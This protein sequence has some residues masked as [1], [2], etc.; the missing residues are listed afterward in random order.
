LTNSLLCGIEVSPLRGDTLSR[1]YN[2]LEG[3]ACLALNIYHEARDQPIE[4]QV[5]VAQVVMERVKSDKYPNS[6][7]EVVMQGPT[8]SWS[9]NYPIKHRCQF[10]WYCDGLSDRPKDMT[11]YLN[12]VDVAEKT[13]HGLKDVV[14]G[15]MYYHSTKVNPWWAKYKIRVRQIGD[16]IFY[17]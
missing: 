4:G 13:L 3:L 15:S 7:C 12:S 5:A 1:R 10:S 16:H 6:I 9:I 2:M 14:K 11:A 8:Y 17:K